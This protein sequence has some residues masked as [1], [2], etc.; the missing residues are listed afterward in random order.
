VVR[1]QAEFLEGSVRVDIF[2]L[3][4]GGLI[5]GELTAPLRPEVPVLVP[6]RTY[7]LEV[8]LR[9]VRLGHLLTQGTTD[10]NELWV[11]CEL[12]NAAGRVGISGGLGPYREVDPWAHF[13]NTY[14]L[15]RFGNR[16]DR[17]NPQ[18]IFT[19]L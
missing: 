2:G 1:R 15:D 8:V 11:E 14:M 18:D 17:R 3:K 16:I 4:E 13:V 7:L 19:P 9:T 10:S 12:G 6:G 5:D